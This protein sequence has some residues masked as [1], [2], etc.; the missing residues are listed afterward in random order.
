M[1][2]FVFRLVH[3]AKGRWLGRRKSRASVASGWSGFLF[4][5]YYFKGKQAETRLIQHKIVHIS[6]KDPFIKRGIPPTSPTSNVCQNM[7]NCGSGSVRYFYISIQE[8]N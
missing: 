5:N 8:F 3:A 1:G 4:T 6:E 7:V 2:V